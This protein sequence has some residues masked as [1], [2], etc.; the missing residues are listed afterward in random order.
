MLINALKGDNLL[1]I[2]FDSSVPSSI[3]DKIIK[4][5][6]EELNLAISAILNGRS[7]SSPKI[8]LLILIYYTL[9]LL[10]APSQ[11]MITNLIKLEFPSFSDKDKLS[12]LDD[13]EVIDLI[14]DI[15]YYNLPKD[16]SLKLLQKR[17]NLDNELGGKALSLYS[18][19]KSDSVLFFKNFKRFENFISYN[20]DIDKFYQYALGITYDY[21][22]D[23]IRIIDNDANEFQIVKNYF[24]NNIYQKENSPK[25]IIDN[26]LELIK[27]YNKYP[28]LCL[29]IAKN[30]RILSEIERD[31]IRFLFSREE[32]LE[33]DRPRT[34]RD[35]DNIRNIVQKR[36]EKM[37][38]NK[39][40]MPLEELKNIICLML[41]NNTQDSLTQMLKIYGNSEEM[42]KLQFNDR[43]FEEIVNLASE[44]EIYVSL[45]E[46]II[47]CDSKEKLINIAANILSNFEY[48]SQITSNNMKLETKMK[49]LYGLESE[50]SLT[51]VTESMRNSF[52]DKALSDKYGVDVYDFS[53]K[54]YLLFAHVKS[55][56]ETVN[57]LVNGYASGNMN[58]ISLSPISYRNQVYYPSGDITFGCDTFPHENFICS[59]VRN[60][61]SNCYIYSNSGEVEEIDRT[62]RGILETSTAIKGVNPETLCQREGLKFQYIILPG[63]REPTN[64]ELEIVKAYGLKFA[65]T[66]AIRKRVE[67]PQKIS[68]ASDIKKTRSEE[69]E[70]LK[71]LKEQLNKETRTKHPKKI[72]IMTDLHGFFEPTLAILADARRNGI[73]EIYSLGDNVGTGP[74]PGEVIDLLDKYGVKS[75][76]GNH[77]LY[78]LEGVEALKEHLEQ[79]GAYGEAQRN[80]TWTRS[81]LT[82]SQIKS[83][84][85]YPASREIL[86][87]GKKI[88]LCHSLK[89]F[90]NEKMIVTPESYD[91]VFVG[92]IHFRQRQ[93]NI[94][95]LRGAGIGYDGTDKGKA[96]YVILTEK[97]NGGYEVEER[98]VPFDV[99]NLDHSINS[100][101]LPV[102]DKDKAA[103]WTGTVKGR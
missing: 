63:G 43:D 23:I 36:F 79:T 29:D 50:V 74:N 28:E 21:L 44:L 42:E 32:N 11:D 47:Y 98:Y 51:K 70:R 59:S 83:L 14:E 91:R 85:M 1:D 66:Q 7:T 26:F 99:V 31:N 90:N 77:E 76:K 68:S 22:P 39:E 94:D 103:N 4:L 53:N 62:Q 6:E 38:N 20:V 95:T 30:N 40:N 100:S 81:K 55:P 2:I 13:D 48:I 96:Y 18:Y 41:F 86:I 71:T 45:I 12:M 37:L 82:S 61:G 33:E 46:D 97:E 89:D 24:F 5:K 78:V 3:K 65:V 60:M 58:F 93:K 25:K 67:N 64:E 101:D 35:C 34:I 92:H 87:G 69:I 73:S 16:L 72:A 49:K 19:F 10:P 8:R 102:Q 80:S 52:L 27:N 75:I 54:A 57:G 88:L 17:F 15:L 84:E 9:E 56:R